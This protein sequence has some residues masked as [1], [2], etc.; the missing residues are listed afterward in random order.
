[1]FPLFVF[2][3]T[4]VWVGPLKSQ[5]AYMGDEREL[6]VHP[7]RPNLTKGVVSSRPLSD[8]LMYRVLSAL[9]ISISKVDSSFHA[10]IRSHVISTLKIQ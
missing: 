2:G 10:L 7:R 6:I 9:I 1:M 3:Q 4:A 5:R 8:D